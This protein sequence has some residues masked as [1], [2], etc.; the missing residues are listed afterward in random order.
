M[1]E[2]MEGGTRCARSRRSGHRPCAGPGTVLTVDGGLRTLRTVTPE[3]D[4]RTRP[5][6]E[7][8]PGPAGATA[9]TE[10][11]RRSRAENACDG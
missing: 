4:P 11:A 5:Q 9:M 3:V 10:L 1:K 7:E 2:S 6:V 8:E